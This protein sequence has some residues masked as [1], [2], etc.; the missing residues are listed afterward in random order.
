M[1]RRKTKEHSIRLWLSEEEYE[2]L[3]QVG[4]I[5]DT[6]VTTLIYRRAIAEMKEADERLIKG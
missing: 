6:A 3:Y 1:S 4:K 2:R 5:C